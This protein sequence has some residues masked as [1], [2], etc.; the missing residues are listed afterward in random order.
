MKVVIVDHSHE[1]CST[2]VGILK[3]A[4]HEVVITQVHDEADV[5]AACR[6]ADAAIA[7]YGQFN[8]RVFEACPKLKIVSNYAMGVDNIDIEDAKAAN[9][10]IANCPDYCFDEVAEHGMTLI[11]S[12][13]RNVVGYAFDVRDGIWDWSKAPKL[14]RIH[15][16]TLGL[17][18]CGQIPRRVAR[19]AQGFGMTVIAY[20]PFLPKAV[21][22]AAGIELV[23]MEELGAR[24]DAVLSH[25][26]LG[27]ST[28]EMVN[29]SVFDTFKKQPVF[30]NTSR[31]L[32]V[33]EHELCNAL[34][35]GRI[36]RAALDVIDDEEPDFREEIFSAPNVFFTPHAAFYSETALDQANRNAAENVTE[37]FAG[38]YDKVRFVVR[39]E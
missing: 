27:K 34:R 35:D 37:F 2:E 33:D 12:L 8:K 22:E 6:D 19:M 24:S 10:A 16:L 1:D 14:K 23:T 5:I 9:V 21:A 7:E 30:V 3:A 39:P 28:R 29:K 25:V 18:G 38:N 36:S 17:I 20:D 32:T 15:G 4:G 31:G 11:A 26:P 13:L